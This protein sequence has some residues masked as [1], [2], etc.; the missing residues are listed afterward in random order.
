MNCETRMTRTMC[1]VLLFV[2]FCIGA[3]TAI[4]STVARP[5]RTEEQLK[6]EEEKYRKDAEKYEREK[7]EIEAEIAKLSL[8]EDLSARF[9]V[10]QLRISGNTLMATEELLEDVPGVYNASDKPL[11]EAESKDLYDFRVLRDI[12]VRPGE[13]REVSTRTIKGFTQYILSVY[14]SKNYAGIYVY[15]PAEAVVAG[16]ELEDEILPIR[17]LEAIVS[18]VTTAYYTPENEKV[19]EGYLK[20]SAVMEWA[21]AKEGEVAN[22]KDLDDF[23]NLLNLNPDRYVSAVISR[24]A[25]PG[26][27]ALGY[28]IYEAN[29]WHWFIQVDN[30]GSKERQWAPRFG[31]INTNLLG[32]DDTFMAMYQVPL[33]SD[34]DENYAL[35]GS[36]DFPLMGPKLR[37]N[38]YGG[39]SEYDTSSDTIS[40][41]NFR[42]SGSFIGGELRYNLFQQDGWFFDITTSMGYE[43]SKVSSDLLG[44]TYEQ[45]D[46]EMHP[47][48]IGAEIHQ[49]DDIS[50]TLFSYERIQNIG[51]DSD[52]EFDDARTDATDE[53]VFHT[54][55]AAHSRY[56]D[57][58]KVERLSANFRWICPEDRL[59]ASKMT[60]LGGLYSVRGYQ[61]D[62]IVADGAIMASAQYEFDMVAFEKSEPDYEGQQAGQ[63]KP[64]LRKLAPLVFVDYGQARVKDPI[65]ASGEE[66]YEDL[67]SVGAGALVELGDN[68]SGGVYYGW[69]LQATEDTETDIFSGRWNFTLMLRW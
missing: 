48:G 67:F 54:V 63:E 21:P 52:S 19:E 13:P 34:W 47:W 4:A 26:S 9:S 1:S 60:V 62:E 23:V 7:E 61:E 14:K 6:I 16:K 39:Y 32:I 58:N 25:E 37:L 27:L 66:K 69:P 8:P 33:E 45:A 38:V 29:P 2:V 53:F 51:G 40:G 30:A 5:D 18:S 42:G 68:F 49:R 44:S 22:Q 55:S 50:N 20:D 12:I 57:T 31:L 43:R 17:V 10:R 35:Y 36:Y 3:G 65:P 56:L 46:L 64:L 24:G 41:F 11:D 28:N 59:V 15:V